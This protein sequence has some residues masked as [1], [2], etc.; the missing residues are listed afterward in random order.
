MAGD[1]ETL[2]L[3]RETSGFG[4]LGRLLAQAALP[5]RTQQMQV[6]QADTAAAYWAEASRTGGRHT[7]LLDLTHEVRQELGHGLSF[8]LTLAHSGLKAL[9]AVLERW[10]RQL[11]GVSVHTVHS[12]VRNIYGKLSVRSKTEAVYEARQL[13]LLR[14]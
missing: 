5:V 1:R 4:D 2:D 9:A 8:Q 6:L 13:G 10:I 7:F 12:H 3:Q 11:L 14:S